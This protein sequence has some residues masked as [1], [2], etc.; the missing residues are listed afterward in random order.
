MAEKAVADVRQ[1]TLKIEPE[2]FEKVWFQWLENIRDWC[3]SRQL[4]WGHRIPAY[5]CSSDAGNA[6]WVAADNRENAKIK[7]AK[8]LNCE[9]FQCVQ[10]DDVLDTW[11]SSALQPFTVF[12]WPE[13]VIVATF[14]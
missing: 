4:W 2:M 1:G 9:Q 12:G 3:I 14:T 13:K 5:Y 10:D 6:V 7:A 11:F 8:L